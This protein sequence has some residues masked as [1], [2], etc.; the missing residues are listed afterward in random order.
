[1]KATG[2]TSVV[3][4]LIFVPMNENKCPKIE[5]KFF[6][7]RFVKTLDQAGNHILS[8]SWYFKFCKV[9]SQGPQPSWVLFSST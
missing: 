4:R 7:A 9:Y 2:L 1:M 8:Q 5:P 3:P 6:R